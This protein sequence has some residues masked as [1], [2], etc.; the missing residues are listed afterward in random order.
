MHDIQMNKKICQ[1]SLRWIL[2]MQ[3][4]IRM[5][6]H[7][8]Y[9]PAWYEILGNQEQIHKDGHSGNSF[10]WTLRQVAYIE[11]HG[12]EKWLSTEQAYGYKHYL[13]TH[14]FILE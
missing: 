2:N 3:N 9:T 8:K 13:D 1:D 5:I 4:E 14:K 12:L 7:F 10:Y 6:K 11:T